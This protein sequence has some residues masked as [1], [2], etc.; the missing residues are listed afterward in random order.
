MLEAPARLNAH[1]TTAPET[2][3]SSPRANGHPAAPA[4][5]AIAHPH[6]PDQTPIERLIVALAAT[7]PAAR[8][9]TTGERRPT[10]GARLREDCTS[11][12]TATHSEDRL[13]RPT[14]AASDLAAPSPA[15]PP[16]T[17]RIARPPTAAPTSAPT[18]R[19][20][21]SF[22]RTRSEVAIGA[23]RI[24]PRSAAENDT[25]PCQLPNRAAASTTTRSTAGPSTSRPWTPMPPAI[26]LAIA[27]RTNTPTI[28]APSTTAYA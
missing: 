14:T 11:Q 2:A 27:P 23:I 19:L 6:G 24:S 8:S 21:S 3:R 5:G 13:A 15:G 4:S 20:C 25:G 26:R 1:A 17:T 9:S 10:R 28:A 16:T 12:L 7:R 22:G 18:R